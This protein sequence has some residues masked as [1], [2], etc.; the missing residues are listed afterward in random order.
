MTW[1]LSSD[2]HGFNTG[3]AIHDNFLTRHTV[4]PAFHGCMYFFH[5][6]IRVQTIS[7]TDRIR[8]DFFRFNH[9]DVHFLQQSSDGLVDNRSIPYWTGVMYAD[10]H[11]MIIRKRE[12]IQIINDFP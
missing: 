4:C 5:I 11:A 7:T 10:L 12:V 8:A 2:L 9:F 3:H 1:N 6:T